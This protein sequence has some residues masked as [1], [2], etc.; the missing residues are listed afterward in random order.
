M[1][2][3]EVEASNKKIVGDKPF[4]LEAMWGTHHDIVPMVERTWNSGEE[5]SS[6]AS[7]KQ[8]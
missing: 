8:S 5:A 2:C 4:R 1:L 6:I 3:N 7:M